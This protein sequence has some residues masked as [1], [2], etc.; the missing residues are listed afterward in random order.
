VFAACDEH[1]VLA[2]GEDARVEGRYQKGGKPYRAA[3][4]N[5]STSENDTCLHSDEQI[6][7]PAEGDPSNGPRTKA[8]SSKSKTTL[9]KMPK[10]A[11]LNAASHVYTDGACVGNPGP[12]GI[13]VVL[14]QPVTDG[15][16]PV[17]IEHSEYLGQGTNN[18]AELT[19]IRRA[20]ELADKRHP[21]V[22]YSDSSYSIGVLSLGWKAKANQ[23][24]VAQI[25]ALLPLFPAVEFVKVL[26]HS[27]VPENERC[28]ELARMAI[29][30][31]R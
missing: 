26:G 31:R 5:L 9:G 15:E 27:G 22:I 10:H 20:L 3:V 7:G 12:M 4:H 24:L 18:I 17:R 13:G 6:V 28:D 25:R 8:S 19:A 1:G 16:T 30:K 29:E 11:S 14:F 23:E 21:V 2:V